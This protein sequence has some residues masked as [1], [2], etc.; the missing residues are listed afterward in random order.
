[1]RRVLPAL[2]VF[3]LAWAAIVLISGGIEVPV[4]GLL[5]R[6]RDPARA[7][8]I[9][10][11]L[12]AVYAVAFRDAIARDMDRLS[13]LARTAAPAAAAI[14]ATL[15]MVHGLADGTF[16]AGGADSYGYVSQAYGWASGDLPD[17][18]P[19]SRLLPALE[20]SV[21]LP[22]GYIAGFVPHTMVPMYAPGLPLMMAVGVLAAGAIG[23]YLVVPAC[24]ALY[25]WF[26]F[27]FGRHVSGPTGGV[28]AALL[29]AASPVVLYQTIWPMSDVPAG[30]FW[31]GAAVAALSPGRRGAILSGL[32]TTAGL[33]IRPNLLPLM[34]VPLAQVALTVY[35]RERIVRAALFLAP[36]APA[37]IFIA[38]LNSMWYGAP[39][40]SGYGT[41][42]QLYAVRNI[43]PNIQRYGPWLWRS[44]SPWILLAPA[45]FAASA[46]A[47]IALGPLRLA[48]AMFVVTLSCYVAYAPFDDW[49]YLRFLLPGLSGVFVLAAAALVTLARRAPHPWGRVAVTVI[50]ILMCRYVIGFAIDRGVFGP[51]KA[52]ERRYT[53][54]GAFIT[55]TLPSNAVFLTMHHSG[56]IRFYAG[57]MTLRF[58]YIPPEWSSN[59]VPEL[60]RRGYHPYLAIDDWEAS[61][62][63]KQF[64]LSPDEALP[65]RLVA[66][67]RAYGGVSVYDMSA[68]PNSPA[69]LVELPTDAGPLYAAP[70]PIE[71]TQLR[72][73]ASGIQH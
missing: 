15:L 36:L 49:W 54:L 29:V 5:F 57:R 34:L 20:D 50:L 37:A 10:L 6:S 26:T 45:A 43:W 73:S 4:A 39:T 60:K 68:S 51:V 72:H 70:L 38:F 28:I 11:V 69:T 21:H 55:R 63:Q 56:A 59:V 62:V 1:V 53:S 16:T 17:P 31:T 44:Q 41:A 33:L 58:D 22:L 19:V 52:R 30:A 9:G 25:V 13:N 48:A 32:C 47:R 27:L 42:E 8:H 66:H 3:M 64:N 46:G 2:I 61:Y 35:G 71:T 14:L 65:W 40:K 67:M 24:A 12:L 18:Y 7:L 23:P